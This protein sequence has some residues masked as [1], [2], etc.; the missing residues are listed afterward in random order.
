M[1]DTAAPGVVQLDHVSVSY[2]RNQ[3]MQDVT[4]VFQTGAVGLLGPN[5]AGK[6]TMLRAL[7]G[8]LRPD[9]GRMRVL[10]FDVAEHPLEIR[11]RLGYM[12]ETDG[13]IPGMNAVSFVAYCGQLAG[14]PAVDAMQR[15]HEVLC[16]VGLGE[17]RYRN[18][19][20]YSSGMKQRI[21]LA[22]ALVHDPDLLF[23]DE[24]TNGMDP[25][26]RDEML[27][28]IRDLAHRKG[29]N[30]ILSSHLLPD[31]EY[32]CDHLVVMDK[33]TVVAQGSLRELK[34]PAGRVVELRVKGELPAFLEAL[35]AA[36]MQCHATEEDI[37]RVF[38]PDARRTTR[39][40]RAGRSPSDAGAPPA[41]Q[42][43][44]AR[45][46]LRTRGRG[47][48]AGNWELGTRESRIPKPEPRV[49]AE[50]PIHDQSYRRYGGQRKHPGSA[51]TVIAWS[52]IRTLITQRRFLL[53]L[54]VAWL[55]FIVRA[56]QI[57]LAA[58]FPQADILRPSPE[59][60]RGFLDQQ[61]IFLLFVT[62][63]VGAGLVANDRRANA[64]QIYLSKP[65]TRVEYVGGKLAVLASFQ[66]LV[67]WVPAML[68]LVLQVMFAG[69]F[70]FI[71]ENLFLIPAITLFASVLVLL[72]AF[73]M[74]ALSSF[75][76]AVASWVSCMWA[77]RCL[78]TRCSIRC[79]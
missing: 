67:T 46:C 68:L 33:G 25:K 16:Y 55:P 61:G 74:L 20:T 79:D 29:V 26:G 50:M 44:D 36:G 43:A 49:A 57:Y 6:S 72:A 30:L 73:T 54:I 60:F 40:L 14:L 28:L 23:L 9:R 76:P 22:Q 4:A 17:E 18:I 63:Y 19:E 78:L 65:L 41:S 12:P 15:A 62:V 51:W 38:I 1:A 37:M 75:S 7:L 69:N 70:T 48:V 53:L 11:T 21:K 66:L 56:V 45:R 10:G 27:E 35:R 39:A 24:P 47:G 32:V 71:G 34:G 5:G 64:L 58:D 8:F 52:G 2:G 31:V 77:S 13:H 42:R 59:T 3:A